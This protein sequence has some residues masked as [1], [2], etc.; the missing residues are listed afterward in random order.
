MKKQTIKKT[1][2]V[3]IAVCGGLLVADG[4]RRLVSGT[5]E[6]NNDIRDELYRNGICAFLDQ[7]KGHLVAVIEADS[8]N[9]M[10]E[11]MKEVTDYFEEKLK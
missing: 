7:G 11:S 8:L 10:K 5:D 4:I 1:A 6:V 2:F 3:M 9:E